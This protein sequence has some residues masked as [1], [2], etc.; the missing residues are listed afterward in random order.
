MGD[1]PKAL[2]HF[3][4]TLLIQQQSLPSTH[5]HLT[6]SY[7]NIGLT[8]LNT[9]DYPKAFSSYEKALIIQQHSYSATNTDLTRTYYSMGM[10]HEKTCSYWK[11]HAYYELVVDLAQRSLPSNHFYL[12]VYENDLANMERRLQ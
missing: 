1:Y 5:P 10:L 12:Q 4:Q 6:F 3:E 7:S 11:A 9:R 8:Y 2:S